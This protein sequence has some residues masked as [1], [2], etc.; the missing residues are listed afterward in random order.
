MSPHE[1]ITVVL[2]GEA[3]VGTSVMALGARTVDQPAA[4]AD[5]ETRQRSHRNAAAGSAVEPNHRCAAFRRPGAGAVRRHRDGGFVLEDQPCPERRR[6]GFAWGQVSF[7]Q[8][9]T[10]ASSRSTARRAGCRHDQPCRRN[11]S[12]TPRIDIDTPSWSAISNRTRA[13]VQRSSDQPQAT[14]PSSRSGSSTAKSW[15]STFGRFAGPEMRR[16]PCPPSRQDR[17]HR[18]TDRTLTRSLLAIT[19][20]FSPR[21][22]PSAASMRTRSRAAWPCGVRPPPCAYLMTTNDRRDQAMSP[23]TT[24]RKAQ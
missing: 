11:N 16:A 24:Q 9:A 7:T 14:A 6:G 1:K 2:P 17:C 8:P 15:S 20:C 10:A 21:A 5:L 18:S 23:P 3:T 22:K 13:R 12:H 19:V 4:L